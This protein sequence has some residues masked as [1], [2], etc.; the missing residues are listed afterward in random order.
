VYNLSIL[1]L[2]P[3]IHS[4]A[5]ICIL[6]SFYIYMKS[7]FYHVSR[8]ENVRF[9]N[10]N[11][12]PALFFNLIVLVCFQSPILKPSKTLSSTLRAKQVASGDTD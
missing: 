9:S 5:S 10:L 8:K 1:V 11:Y 6:S 7:L 12:F 3:I 4:N 2:S